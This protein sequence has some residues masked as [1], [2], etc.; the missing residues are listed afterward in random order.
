MSNINTEALFL[1]VNAV[2]LALTDYE[3]AQKNLPRLSLS[4][5][6][7]AIQRFEVA[8][9]LS[10]QLL[11]RVL[12]EKFGLDDI[13]ANNKTFIREAAKYALI[14]DAESWMIYLELRNLSSHTYDAP[15]AERVF[16]HI[17]NF[18][19]DARDLLKRLNH[20]IT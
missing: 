15:V 13:V 14:A 1:A 16:A 3:D 8:M 4:V 17:P 9:D 2:E 12:K 10:R 20:A 6:D 19:Q 18:L 5:R 11:L 7:G